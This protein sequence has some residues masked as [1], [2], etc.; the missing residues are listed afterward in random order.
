MN[1]TLVTRLW[2]AAPMSLRGRLVLGVTV[3]ATAAVLASQLIGYAV[4]R[5]WLL[6]R[7]DRQLTGFVPPSPAFL[8]A[9]DGALPVSD[10]GLPNALPSDFQ[11]HFYDASGRLLPRALAADDRPGPR[12]PDSADD[13]GLREGHP[14]TVA[15][16]GGDT[17]W[18][19]LLDSGPDGLRAVVALPL[20]TVEDAT[21][22]FLWLGAALLVATVAALLALGRWVVR[23]GLLPLTRTERVAARIAAGNLDL[24]LPDTDPRTE[25]GRLG[26]V[27]DS[28]L[29]R[30]RTALAER[31]ASEERLRRFVADAGHE[32]RTPLTT[33]QGYA[34]LARR[35]DRRSPDEIAEADRLI[36]QNAQRMSLLVDDLHL[37]AR[38][39]REPSYRK[40]PVDLLS[41][42]ADA[43]SAAAV[44]GSSH[45]VDLGPLRDRADADDLELV[46]TLG[47]PH[48]LRQVLENL[49]SNARTHTPDG[50]PVHVRVGTAT[51]GPAT[52]GTERPGRVSSSPPLEAGT[53]V[54]VVEV[55][56]EG[57]GIPAR[58][59]EHVFERFYR[60]DPSRSRAHGGSGLGLAIAAAI[61]EG[62]GGRLELDTAPRAGSTFRLVVP[63][64]PCD[65]DP[66]G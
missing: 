26:H 42:A 30:L 55:A 60:V 51:V 3:L 58:H 23:L 18:R 19:V 22:A 61:A 65:D 49:L 43:V 36:L 66:V 64:R 45:P 31:E 47:D 25:V 4:L 15:A 37:L 21:S 9:R 29:D 54:G 11:V 10:E 27:L 32:L 28:M 46:G 53:P 14:E 16:V 7:T 41:L 20:D 34:E 2:R 56:D 39:D 38:L 8:D 63:L 17:D 57:P 13:L 24:R 5:S 62:H 6:D 40:A 44:D 50:T 12:L 59:A 33:I 1:D 35:G 52:G 48:R